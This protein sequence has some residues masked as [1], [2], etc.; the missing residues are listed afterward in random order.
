LATTT[1]VETG[2]IAVLEC[3]IAKVSEDGAEITIR[4]PLYG[5]PVTIPVNAAMRIDKRAEAKPKRASR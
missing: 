2:D 5:Y 3:P 4:V 1:R